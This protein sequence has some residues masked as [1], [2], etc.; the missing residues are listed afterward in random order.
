M[1]NKQ[2]SVEW[3]EDELSKLNSAVITAEITQE[4]YHKQRVG[5]WEKAKAM[6]EQQIKEAYADGCMGA[7]YEVSSTYTSEEY[8]NATYGK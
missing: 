8:Y 5:L 3:I 4:E 1:E 2:T 7:M 6:E